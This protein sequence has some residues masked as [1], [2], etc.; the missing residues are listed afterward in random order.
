MNLEQKIL[1]ILE[2]KALS[3][4]ELLQRLGSDVSENQLAHALYLLG[5][6]KGLVQKHP[7]IGGG[8]TTCACN[9]SYLWRLTFSGRKEL[10]NNKEQNK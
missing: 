9:I 2:V 10:S 4:E 3:K 8:C 6:Q 1:Q 5:D 7:V